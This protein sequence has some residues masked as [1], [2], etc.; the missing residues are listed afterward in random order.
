VAQFASPPISGTD[1]AAGNPH[2]DYRQILNLKSL[3]YTL[4][5]T[6]WHLNDIIKTKGENTMNLGQEN[7]TTEFKKSTAELDSGLESISAI[8]NKSRK[9]V[10]YFGVLNNG[11]VVG[12]QV[13]DTTARKVAEAISQKIEPR[14][15]PTIEI[16][17]NCGRKYIKVS[18][19]GKDTPYSAESI[20]YTRVFD[21]DRKASMAEVR[22]LF[23]RG[24]VDG[25]RDSVASRNIDFSFAVLLNLLTAKGYHDVEGKEF[26]ENRGLVNDDGQVNLQGELLSDQSLVSIKLIRYEGIDKTIMK[27]RKEF[28]ECSLLVAQQKMMDYFDTINE[29]K[30]DLSKTPRLEIRLFDKESVSEAWKNAVVHNNW[31]NLISPVVYLFNDRLEIVSYGGLPSDLGKEEFYHGKSDPVNPSLFDLFSKLG[32]VE[33]GGHGVTT[34]VGKYGKESI[35]ITPSMITVRIPFAFK[36]NFAISSEKISKLTINQKAFV[37]EVEE[38]PEMTIKEF[39]QKTGLGYGTVNKIIM[40]LKEKGILSR[41]GGNKNGKWVLKL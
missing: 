30:V 18:F 4:L 34:I 35:E 8:L 11:D 31:K 12:Q 17:D 23:F 20:V 21:Q 39:C 3:L 41:E 2:G 28:G 10:L 29:T 40:A 33:Q 5:Y 38:K 1:P 13:N 15:Y 9:G 24:G 19:A 36:P 22:R 32:I 37:S 16:L 27:E 25:L 6:F 14:I 26:R 7:E